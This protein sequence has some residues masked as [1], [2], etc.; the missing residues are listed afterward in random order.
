[1]CDQTTKEEYGQNMTGLSESLMVYDCR[2]CCTYL[3]PHDYKS[4]VRGKQGPS[5]S[6]WCFLTAGKQGWRR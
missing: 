4:R 2:V 6:G 1:M 3:V 5:R